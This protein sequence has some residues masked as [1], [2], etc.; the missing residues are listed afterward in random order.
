MNGDVSMGK[1]RENAW[2]AAIIVLGVSIYLSTLAAGFTYDDIQTILNNQ[3]VRGPF[4]IVK[5]LFRDFWGRSFEHTIGTWR[6]VATLSFWVDWHLAGGHPLPFHVTNLIA[7]GSL[8]VIANAFLARWGG[9]R[10]TVHARL[11]AVAAFAALVI[12]VDVVPGATGR[13]E[14][15]A[16]A[17][18]L[19]AMLVA[20]PERLPLRP[21]RMLVATALLTLAMASKESAFPMAIVV[22]WMVGRY[23]RRNGTFAWRPFTVFT[24]ACLTVLGGMTIFRMGRLPFAKVS[25]ALQPDNPLVVMPWWE[26]KL[27]AAEVFTHYL[28]HTLTGLDL[29]PDYSYFAVP[30]L[31]GGPGLRVALGSLVI[32]ALVFVTVRGWRAWPLATDALVGFAGAFLAASHFVVPAS[33]ML[34]DRLFFFPSFWLTVIVAVL[35]DQLPKLTPGST[36]SVRRIG[37]RRIAALGIAGWIVVQGIIATAAATMWR[38]DSVLFTQA[39]QTYPHVS[40]T[41]VNFSLA[42]AS[43]GRYED[44]AWHLVLSRAYY[45]RFPHP[46][47]PDDFP[48]SWDDLPVPLRLQSLREHLGDA[49]FVTVLNSALETC[50]TWNLHAQAQVIGYWRSLMIAERT[51][52]ADTPSAADAAPMHSGAVP[53]ASTPPTPDTETRTPAPPPASAPPGSPAAT[54]YPPSPRTS[55]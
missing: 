16:A 40:R 48:L 22:P 10:L 12:H 13:T 39:I 14:M 4:S 18:S 31:E 54:A 47:A 20:M 29:V 9:D 41:R 1:R 45:V 50:R 37:V 11:L 3:T 8:L 17:F 26:Q 49:L 53:P 55:P 28:E 51:D 34:A 27:A 44:A 43:A 2:T 36:Q 30:V 32:A 46:I 35:L 23:L 21:W 25:P 33:A 15:F 52:A 24:L 6:P 42:L 7:Y 38:D 5:L 19:G